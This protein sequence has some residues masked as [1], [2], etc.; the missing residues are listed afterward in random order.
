MLPDSSAILNGVIAKLGADAE[1]LALVPDNVHEDLG[2]PAAKRFVVVSQILATDTPMFS[3]GRVI[4]DA[5][6]LVEA[7]V[8]KGVGSPATAAAAAARIDA[9]LDDGTLTVPGYRVTDMHREEFVRGTEVDEVDPTIVWKRRGGR[10]RVTVYREI[11][12]SAVAAE[13]GAPLTADPFT[14]LAVRIWFDGPV[15]LDP[16]G[17]GIYVWVQSSNHAVVSDQQLYLAAN[18]SDFS[19][20]D[21]AAPGKAALY[22]TTGANTTTWVGVTFTLNDASPRGNWHRILNRESGE[23]VLDSLGA[24][25]LQFT[26]LPPATTHG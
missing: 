17:P 12:A 22:F 18:R 15:K 4:E 14:A 2:P 16:V 3:Q 13:P 1:L 7:R 5:L 23:P 25:D 19:V 20:S 8:L 9:L 24:V 6:L 26:I 21:P 11:V 10:Y